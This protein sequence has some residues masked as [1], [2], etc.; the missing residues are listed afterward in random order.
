MFQYA[1]VHTYLHSGVKCI[2]SYF[3]HT[4]KLHLLDLTFLMLVNI[5]LLPCMFVLIF[6]L[7]TLKRNENVAPPPLSKD[8]VQFLI[9]GELVR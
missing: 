4:R 7:I 2:N 5:C 6:S 8:I 9:S 1:G 3:S